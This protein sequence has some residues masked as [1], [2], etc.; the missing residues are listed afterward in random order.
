MNI[1]RLYF[2]GGTLALGI[3][4]LAIGVF[5]AIEATHTETEV[6]GAL[7]HEKVVVQDPFILLTYPNARAPQGVEIPKVTIDTAAEAH[8]Q[9]QV[10]HA[11]VMA[12]TEGKGW[13]ELSRKIPDPNDPTKMIDNPVRN[14]YMWGL[15][16]QNALHQAHASLEIVKLVKVIGLIFSVLGAGIIALGIPLSY[17]GTKR[18]SFQGA[19]TG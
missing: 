19:K 13:T 2:M 10:I 8:A 7:T 3:A 17:L 6:T 1:K 18:R 5:M 15:T 11:H 12:E 4:L 9:A 14:T 16:L